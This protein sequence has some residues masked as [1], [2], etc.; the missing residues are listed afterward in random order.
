MPI[1]K[2][3]EYG[4]YNSNLKP[5]IEYEMTPEEYKK[6]KKTLEKREKK[7]GGIMKEVDSDS[8]TEKK[9]I[10]KKAFDASLSLQKEPFERDLYYHANVAKSKLSKLSDK[11]KEE[12]VKTLEN[13]FDDKENLVQYVRDILPEESRG[14]IISNIYL[15]KKGFKTKVDIDKYIIDNKLIKNK[16]SLKSKIKKLIK[17]ITE[18]EIHK[19]KKGT[20]N[21]SMIMDL[22]RDISKTPKHKKINTEGIEDQIKEVEKLLKAK[23]KA[24]K[25]LVKA[26]KEHIKYHPSDMDKK[27][28]KLDTKIMKQSKD[29]KH[30]AKNVSSAVRNYVDYYIDI[31]KNSKTPQSRSKKLNALKVK[32]YTNLR[33]SDADDANTLIAEFKKTLEPIVKAKGTTKQSSASDKKYKSVTKYVKKNKP[34]IKDVDDIHIIVTE[35]IGKDKRMSKKLLDEVFKDLEI[36]GSGLRKRQR[37]M[38]GGMIHDSDTEDEENDIDE[39][40]GEADSETLLDDLS[41]TIDQGQTGLNDDDYN[42]FDGYLH[43][44][45]IAFITAYNQYVTTHPGLHLHTTT[46]TENQEIQ[47]REALGDVIINRGEERNPQQ[48]GAIVVGINNILY[49]MQ[50]AGTTETVGPALPT[51]TVPAPTGPARIDFNDDERPT[52]RSRGSGIRK[53]KRQVKKK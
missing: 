1:V 14:Y 46:P 31:Y 13:K 23:P 49:D 24:L 34:S 50:P 16:T 32:L 10:K 52:K 2:N 15:E 5:S 28:L 20:K 7:H 18:T 26:D 47:L 29:Y 21:I 48:V 33:P 22:A 12:Y 3:G 53:P 51:P 38:K 37:K 42:N 41:L 44:D 45:P 27:E 35:L 25:K 17:E 11:E 8:D 36:T 40:L 9:P 30:K 39:E 4:K 19:P 6:W 43:D